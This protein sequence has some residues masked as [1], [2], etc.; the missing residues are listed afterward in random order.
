MKSIIFIKI[1]QFVKLIELN[2]SIKFL[3]FDKLTKLSGLQNFVRK[4]LITIHRTRLKNSE[5]D[6]IDS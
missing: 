5:S 2:K 4:K 3:E 1:K 6:T